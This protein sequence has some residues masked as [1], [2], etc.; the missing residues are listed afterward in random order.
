MLSDIKHTNQ[1]LCLY[2]NLKKKKDLASV[3][4]SFAAAH[5]IHSK[6]TWN[7]SPKFFSLMLSPVVKKTDTP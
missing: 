2:Y 7:F 6:I 1:R 5:N 4:V 3:F